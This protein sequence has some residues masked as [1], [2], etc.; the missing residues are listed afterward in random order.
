MN[1]QRKSRPGTGNGK[2]NRQFKSKEKI[3]VSCSFI[4]DYA[5][6][7]EIFYSDGGKQ[8]K[9]TSFTKEIEALENESELKQL[10]GEIIT[11]CKAR[12]AKA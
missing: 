9:V 6:Y 12:R 11:F 4:G 8:Y 10:V 2:T 5:A 3:L 7:L 1:Y